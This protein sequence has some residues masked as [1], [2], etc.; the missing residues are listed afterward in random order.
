M[1]NRRPSCDQQ[2]LSVHHAQIPPLSAVPHKPPGLRVSGN[3]LQPLTGRL[4][5]EIRLAL[6]SLAEMP[7]KGGTVQDL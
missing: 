6:T 2:N 5:A 3:L 7:V 4:L 1:I